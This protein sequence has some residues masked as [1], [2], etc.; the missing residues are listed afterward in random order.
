M[1]C[2]VERRYYEPTPVGRGERK[3]PFSFRGILPVIEVS[4]QERF[5]FPSQAQGSWWLVR[6]TATLN[7]LDSQLRN[8]HRDEIERN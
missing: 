3:I 6:P 8:H 1:L 2:T 4:V 7:G 5:H